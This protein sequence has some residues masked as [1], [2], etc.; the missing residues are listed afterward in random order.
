MNRDTLNHLPVRETANATFAILDAVQDRNAEQALV[1][2]FCAAKMAAEAA[3]IPVQDVV[4]VA[5]NIMRAGDGV[6]PEFA[7]FRNY[8]RNDWGMS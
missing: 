6:R 5:D 4:A 2:M 3:R 1:A 8:L 7:A